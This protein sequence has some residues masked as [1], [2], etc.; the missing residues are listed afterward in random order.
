MTKH[1]VALAIRNRDEPSKVL[2]VRRPDTDEEF[3]GM[4]GLPA[5][6]CR[7]GETAEDAAQRT[8]NQKLGAKLR[9]GRKLASGKQ[10]RADYTIEMSLYEAWLGSNEPELPSN[11]GHSTGT[12]LYTDWRWGHSSE[13]EDSARRGSLCSRL[14]LD[15]TGELNS[16]L[17][18]QSM[19]PGQVRTAVRT[20]FG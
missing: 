7:L 20:W 11:K 12:T 5:A 13:L 18:T 10:E 4:W 15:V 14:L 17:G 16:G 9:L 8:A 19:G 6:S 2:L 3:P 1:S